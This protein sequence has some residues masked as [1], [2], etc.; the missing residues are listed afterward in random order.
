M[1]ELLQILFSRTDEERLHYFLFGPVCSSSTE[2]RCLGVSVSKC[3]VLVPYSICCAMIL[4]VLLYKWIRNKQ[5]LYNVMLILS[6]SS[7][8]L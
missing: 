7:L 2:G 1:L 4:K 5:N 8:A 3:L 6:D